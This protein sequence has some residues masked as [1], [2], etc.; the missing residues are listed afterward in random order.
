MLLSVQ[1]VA[2][3]EENLI[4]ITPPQLDGSVSMNTANSLADFIKAS[5][6]RSGARAATKQEVED[7]MRQSGIS[8]LRSRSEAQKV[9]KAMKAHALLRYQAGMDGDNVELRISVYLIEGGKAVVLERTV[10]SSELPA[11]VDKMIEEILGK[12]SEA[13]APG[14]DEAP[15]DAAPPAAPPTPPEPPVVKSGPGIWASGPIHAQGGFVAGFHIGGSAPLGEN[16]DDLDAGIRVGT[17][18]GYLIQ[19]GRTQSLTP[20]MLISYTNW[21]LGGGYYSP[22]QV[23]I[24]EFSGGLGMFNL[25]AGLRYSYYIGPID[26]WGAG[27]FGLGHLSFT[28]ADKYDSSMKIDGSKAGFAMN[29]EAGAHFMIVRYI[30]AGLFL[31]TTKAFV[32][33]ITLDEINDIHAQYGGMGFAV[34]LNI[35]GKVPL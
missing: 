16:S 6:V 21:G 31:A 27:H 13:A 29:F 4:L 14:T 34:G 1:S 9:A 30:G 12:P 23:N 2:Q 25:M 11:T 33:K 26:I 32:D 22:D 10:A 35:K 17:N 28:L 3:A 5:L 20:E 8:S 18:L 24:S 19:V 7:H 15:G